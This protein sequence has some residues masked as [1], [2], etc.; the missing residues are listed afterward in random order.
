MVSGVRGRWCLQWLLLTRGINFPLRAWSE[1]GDKWEQTPKT[2]DVDRCNFTSQLN[3]LFDGAVLWQQL[4]PQ[5]Q[6]CCDLANHFCGQG[7]A[8]SVTRQNSH[9][10]G[11]APVPW[12]GSSVLCPVPWPSVS[13]PIVRDICSMGSLWAWP[14]PARPQLGRTPESMLLALVKFWPGFWA[15]LL[16]EEQAVW[17]QERKPS[18]H[19]WSFFPFPLQPLSTAWKEPRRGICSNVKSGSCCH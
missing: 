12:D 1:R 18:Q 11:T 8:G 16:L 17:C 4:A 5:T 10:Q 14:Q 7:V 15:P 6:R 13:W 19:S 2:Y 9:E 3:F